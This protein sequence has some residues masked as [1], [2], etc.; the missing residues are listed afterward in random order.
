LSRALVGVSH[1]QPDFAVFFADGD[2]LDPDLLIQPHNVL[3][4]VNLEVGET[5]KNERREEERMG[6]DEGMRKSDRGR[7]EQRRVL[8]DVNEALLL[9]PFHLHKTTE[10]LDHY[11]GAAGPERETRKSKNNGV[12]IRKKRRNGGRREMMTDR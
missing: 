5:D 9:E 3:R 8:R 2:D 7:R 1:R 6:D 12:G 4:L 11:H 10:I